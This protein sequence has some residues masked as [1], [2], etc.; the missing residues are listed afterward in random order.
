MSQAA[1]NLSRDMPSSA[2]MIGMMKRA[3]PNNEI[4]APYIPLPWQLAPMRDKTATILLTG[5][6]GGGK[7][8]TA[9]EKIHAF[10]KKYPGAMAVMMRKSR[11]SMTNSTVLFFDKAIVGNDPNVR[12][13]PSKLRFEY[14]NGSILAYGGMSDDQQREQIRSIGQD[15][16]IDICWMEEANRFTEDDYNEVLGRMRGTAAGWRQIILSTN[17][18]SPSHWIKR[19][20]M[21][22]GGAKVYYSKA[23]DNT[24]NPADYLS[25]LK[26]LTGVLGDRLNLGKWIQ[27]EGAVY[28]NFR[29]ELHVI[30]SFPIPADWR[31]I[32]VVDFGFT[33]PFV[34]LW[35]ALDS[36]GRA[37]I[38]REI[39]KTQTLVED[40]TA[41]I[42]SLSVNE[43][44]ETTLADH[45][46]EDRATMHR[47][48]ISTRAAN[49]SKTVGIQMV[50]QRLNKAG[51]DKPRFYY[52]RDS[53]VELDTTLPDGLPHST[54]DEFTSYSWPKGQDG[55]PIKEEP[56]KTGDHGMDAL[57]YAIMY[58]DTGIQASS[59]VDFA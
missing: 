5:S 59:L 33:N 36:D 29:D 37:Y 56:I 8:R 4:I 2:Q 9:A 28:D 18:D 16:G 45:D 31:R 7:S 48:G 58:L 55:K 14:A 51:D 39:Y 53:L 11:Q 12:H 15:G 38:Y 17:P 35:I 34:C 42:L 43:S 21:D 22:A 50:M 6:A 27:A 24:Y 32:R 1:V 46:A 52:M 19:R 54:L 23:K 13:Y 57:R 26:K 49:K 20:L 40:H 10:C 47:Y 3:N 41:H 25:T 44:F 30:D